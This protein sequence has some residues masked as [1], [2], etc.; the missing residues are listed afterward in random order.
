[1]PFTPGRGQLYVENSLAMCLSV[2]FST[3]SLLLEGPQDRKIKQKQITILLHTQEGER[4]GAFA[5]MVFNADKDFMV[6]QVSE[7]GLCFTTMAQVKDKAHSKSHM[8][9]P[10]KSP[11]AARLA[12]TRGDRP[13]ARIRTTIDFEDKGTINYFSF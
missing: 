11:L 4:Y 13:S 6:A 9:S 5:C 3:E 2:G 10:I 8:I 12:A 7:S 1:V